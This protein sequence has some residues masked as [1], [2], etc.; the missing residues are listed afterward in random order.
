MAGPAPIF[1]PKPQL[2]LNTYSDALSPAAADSCLY[3]ST[4]GPFSSASFPF[5]VKRY[6]FFPFATGRRSIP[7]GPLCGLLRRPGQLSSMGDESA[8]GPPAFSIRA[9]PS[10]HPARVRV[11]M[12]G[13]FSDLFLPEVAL[14]RFQ[15]PVAASLSKTAI[16][17]RPRYAIELR[18]RCCPRPS[19]AGAD[20][21]VPKSGDQRSGERRPWRKQG[22][23]KHSCRLKASLHNRVK[24]SLH[25]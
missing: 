5:P 7:P 18:R 21:L 1:S 6:N 16:G 17:S 15:G 13:H 8:L 22:N 9:L 12:V 24:A 2:L 19:C 4:A 20:P 10:R 11:W 23:L 14:S 3:T 25:N